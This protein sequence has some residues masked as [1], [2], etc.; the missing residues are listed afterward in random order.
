[1]ASL[2]RDVETLADM[3]RGS[4]T[5]G[6]RASAEWLARRLSGIGAADVRLLTFRYSRSFAT[7][8]AAHYAAGAVGALVGG[9]VGAA[10]ALAA[11][12]SYELDFSGRRQWLRALLPAGEGTTVVGRVPAQG[13]R[14]QTLVLVAHHDA[15]H[16]GLIFRLLAAGRGGAAAERRGG[17]R[18][19]ALPITA[20]LALTAL[21]ALVA[22][23]LTRRLAVLLFAGQVALMADVE[24]SDTVPGASDN[25][26]GVAGVLALVHEFAHRRLDGTEVVVVLPG[27]EESGMGGMAAWIRREGVQLDPASTLVLG[28]DTLGAGEPAILSAEGP[29]RRERYPEQVLALADRGAALAGL[30]PPRRWRIGGWTDPVLAVQAGL[31]AVSIVSTRDGGF[32]N[33]HLPTD[34]ADR[35]DWQSVERSVRLAGG[36]AR[37]FARTGLRVPTS[38]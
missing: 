11:A 10:L 17:V 29:V 16:T 35:V 20:G 5:P 28:L 14:R 30:D 12:A 24:R 21:G 8:H 9:P 13:E 4:A 36:T 6:E 31:P 37:D 19:F 38:G 25:A 7:A 32:T 34:T 23:R 2:R 15:A 22:P 18:S 1:M 27:C 26:T 3:E 33:Y